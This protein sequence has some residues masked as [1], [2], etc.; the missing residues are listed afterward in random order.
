MIRFLVIIVVSFAA[1]EFFSY[2]VHRYVYHGLLWF[3]HKSHHTPRTGLFEWND[4]FPFIFSAVTIVLMMTALTS[5]DGS[6]LLALSIGI[7][8]YGVVYLVI[9]DLYVHRRMKALH[10]RNPFLLRV[11]KAHM[12][13]HTTGGEPYGLLLFSLPP[14]LTDEERERGD[15]A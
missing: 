5:P 3:V 10:F 15:I 12:V 8:A 6:E 11:K 9:H 4:V 13:H 14:R 2:L 1:M 7:T